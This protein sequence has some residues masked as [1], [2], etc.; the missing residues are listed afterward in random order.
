MN[1]SDGKFGFSVQKKLYLKCGG[2]PLGQGVSFYVWKEFCAEVGWVRQRKQV[3]YFD[4]TFD[5]SAPP[6]HLPHGVF[7]WGLGFLGGE[8]AGMDISSVEMGGAFF[9]RLTNCRL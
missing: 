2:T 5:I 7:L 3:E 4:L 6:G 8:Y 1:Y 9:S